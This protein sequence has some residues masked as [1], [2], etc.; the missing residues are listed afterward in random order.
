MSSPVTNTRGRWFIASLHRWTWGAALLALLICLTLAQLHFQQQQTLVETKHLLG[1]IRE[2]RVD[3][4]K[5]YLTLALSGDDQSP[6]R[7]VEGLALLDQ[8]IA[9]L[10]QAGNEVSLKKSASIDEAAAHDEFETSAAEFRSRLNAWKEAESDAQRDLEPGLRVA[11]HELE[12][13]AGHVDLATQ[14]ELNALVTQLSRRFIFALAA[15]MVLL[16]GTCLGVFIA[17]RRERAAVRALH[18]SELRLR[19]VGDN[20]PN[21]YV[22][23]YQHGPDGTPR[24]T[25][26]SAG[27]ERVHGVTAADV[28]RDAECLH[29]QIDPEQRPLLAAT[30]S[31]S[32]HNLTDFEM[33]LRMRRR[34]G[35]LRLVRLQARPRRTAS[36]W[37]QW[38]GFA[39]DVTERQRTEAA[40]RQ[41]L[42]LQDQ[43]AKIA[44]T[45]PGM[46]F[47]FQLRPDGSA[48]MPFC[49]AASEELW[50]LRPEDLRADFSPV[51]HRVHADDVARLRESIAESARTLQP[52][53]GTF[54]VRH[55]QKGERWLEGHSLPRPDPDGSTLWHGFLQ[56]ITE[57]KR[58]EAALAA[59][60]IRR[61]ILIEQSRDGMVV[62]DAQGKVY[63]ANLRYAEML[64]YT[65]E[66]VRELHVWDW[67]KQWGREQLLEMIQRS[68]ARGDHFETRHRR[69]DGSIFDVEISTNGAVLDGQ[70]L[71]FCV[72]RDISQRKRAQA[73]QSVLFELGTQ[74]SAARTAKA[75]AEII[76]G[77]ADQLFGWDACKLELY[78]HDRKQS[79]EILTYDIVEGRRVE[80]TEP[81][82]WKSP[83]PLVLQ[84]VDQ[85]AR[86]VLKSK[87]SH[88]PDASPFGNAARPSASI[89]YAPTRHGDHASGVLSIHSYT[90]NAYTPEDLKDFQSLADHCGG[91]L[92]RIR[93]EEALAR[94]E[95]RYRGLVETTFDWIWEV[96][97]EGRYTYAS[98]KVK[99]LLGYTPEEVLGRTPF[100][101]MPEAEAQ[102]VGDLFRTIAVKHESF[103]ALENT[104][105]HKDGHRVTL[106]TSGVPVLD[107][108]GILKGYRGMDRDI[109]ERKR[110]EAQLRQAQ[111]LEAIGQLAGGVAHDFNNIL[112]ATMMHLGLLQ[113]NTH[114]DEETRQTLNDLEAE[115]RRAAALTRQLLMFSRRSVLAV[116]PLDINAVVANLLKMLNRLIGEHIDLRFD[117]KAG[118]PLVEADAGMLEQVLMNLVVNARD[119]LPKGGRIV[120]STALAGFDATDLAANPERRPGQFLCL[121]V[122]D[123][124]CGMDAAI[125][126]H[127][128]EPFFT[129]KEAGKGTGLGLATVHGIVAQHK[130]WVELES[131]PGNGA[132]FRVFL[133]ALTEAAEQV[134]PTRPVESL[135]RGRETILLVED[136]AQVRQIV[137]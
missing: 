3:L 50:G 127:I 68:D 30:E 58:A 51:F 83:S 111:K 100:D 120:I 67:D 64:G 24:F 90:P 121:A 125:V 56:D 102:R 97:A 133:P 115:A 9:V 93:A 17:G 14:W 110:L 104:N 113:M 19:L 134:V 11:F 12:R 16:G 38:D 95:E 79:S 54:R 84:I 62:L 116:K 53:Q 26:V 4:A 73:R 96:D 99:D 101:F 29:G 81:G 27:V 77:V 132:T 131:E 44:A 60:A 85:G 65:V 1:N 103:S 15:A 42:E 117:G 107:T 43:V 37:V 46:I 128:F 118:L 88:M 21:S 137:G 59:E 36:G 123:T 6:L 119:A 20:L 2:A 34:D 126:K 94:S 10:Q 91:A 31:E 130:G 75:A 49:T 40:L 114:L 32:A 28:L 136:E 13:R 86:L 55:P 45:V 22:Y 63:E 122:S 72:C 92:E 76:V 106:E 69:K 47:S 57:R 89:M 108:N 78:S 52:W 109:T 41:R 124:G 39:I 18:D 71:V 129:T 87:A 135:R 35:E 112:A 74:L 48:C 61:R 33:D 23:E 7:R 82:V 8:A 105:Q 66:E 98:P 80:C 5:G 70:K 25:Y